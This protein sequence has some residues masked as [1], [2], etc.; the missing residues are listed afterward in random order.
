MRILKREI[1]GKDQS[2]RLKVQADEAED[3][4]H[5]YNIISVGDSIVASTVRNFT[6]EGSTGSTTKSRVHTTLTIAAEKVE[7]DAE[8]CALRI[9]GNRSRIAYVS[10]L[11]L[12]LYITYYSGKNV[13][14]NEFVKLGQYH[15]ID[16]DLAIPFWISKDCWDEIFL[17]R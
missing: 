9:S 1:S 5:L 2:G 10:S 4:Y 13:A 12:P 8:R 7:F 17:E 14:E 3:M 16:I 11:S 6:R 15:T